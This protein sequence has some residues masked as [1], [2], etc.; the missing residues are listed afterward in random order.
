M[1]DELCPFCGGEGGNI[2]DEKCHKPSCYFVKQNSIDVG[3]GLIKEWNTRPIEDALRK[4]LM[5]LHYRDERD[6]VYYELSTE[7]H[8]WKASHDNLVRQLSVTSDSLE[9]ATEGL[10][11]IYNQYEHI[12]N[13]YAQGAAKMASE[14]LRRL[15]E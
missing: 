2:N 8:V 9:I 13:G 10:V 3:Y 6:N 7:L 5:V 1:S 11:D 4:Q 12:N 14:T 15:E